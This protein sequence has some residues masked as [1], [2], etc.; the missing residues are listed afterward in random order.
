MERRRSTRFRLRCEVTCT[1]FDELGVPETI[2]GCAHDIS[3]GGL[4]VICVQRP[5][6]GAMA[7]LEIRLPSRRLP[8]QELQLHGCGRVV[9]ILQD[10]DPTGFAVASSFSWTLGRSKGL[11]VQALS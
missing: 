4:F 3:A 8:G 2:T 9:R 10:G 7:N 5:P 6:A 11:F 1:W